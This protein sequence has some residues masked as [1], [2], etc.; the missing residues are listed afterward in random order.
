M[1]R[2]FA[3]WPSRGYV[4]GLTLGLAFLAG[5]SLPEPDGSEAAIAAKAEGLPTLTPA[6]G[7]S[8]ETVSRNALL[9]SPSVR[10]AASRVS[11]SADEVRVQRAV[12]FPSLGL[13]ING[14]VGD[15]GEE[16]TNIDLEGRQLIL[17]FGKTKRA[18]TAADLDLQINYITFQQ[19][20]DTAIF[21]VLEAYDAVSKNVQ[22][23]D[24]RRKQLAAMRNL[25][26]MVSDRHN[27][28]AAPSSDVLETRK[29]LQ[30]AEFLVHDTELLL[31]EGR[32]RLARLSGQ[33]RG[34]RLPALKV[35]TCSSAENSDELRKARLELAK[36]Q[37]DLASAERARL[38]RAY[39]EPLARH[40]AG[41][42]GISVGMNVGIDS[43]L[44]QGGALTARAN[45]ARNKSAGAQAGVS[46]ARRDIALDVG[47]LKREIAA[48]G[49]KSSML[50]R[51]I[52]LLV[53]TRSLY[54][55]QYFDL[56]TREVSELLDN[57]EEYYNRKAE[58]IELNSELGLNRVECAIR[59]QTLRNAVGVAG[60]KI[61][62]YP[63]AS[64][65]F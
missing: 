7:R 17:D 43:D 52:S 55:S 58:L 63:L 41:T 14:G 36:A 47:Q 34:G 27:I 13:S 18:V 46:A 56:G 11:A 12:I 4:I 61:Y 54:R 35:G 48:A 9:L 38:P 64:S 44:L 25:Q 6:E 37:L 16:D 24:V 62:G 39:I 5:C 33:S 2:K 3:A 51:Q 53:Q 20:V 50:Q 60:S 1:S 30:A 65:T 31:A 21:E 23:L 29:R 22:I 19:S 59:Q 15:A 28:G 26:K 49:K 57:E 45:A 32:D 8:P 40:K 42:G 10:E